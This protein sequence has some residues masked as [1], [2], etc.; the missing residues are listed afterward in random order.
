[1]KTADAAPWSLRWRLLAATFVATVAVAVL[2]GVWLSTL[3]RDE[4]A[5]Q[6][7]AALRTQ[8]DEVTARF[9]L[10]AAGVPA[11]DAAALSDPRWHQPQ[12]GLYWQ[13]DEIGAQGSS[14]GALRSRSLW[15]AQLDSPTDLLAGGQTH[16]HTLTGPDGA[17][18]LALERTV[19]LGAGDATR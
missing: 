1:M 19:Q 7:A 12:S 16:V 9:E 2:A 14:R 8:L 6:F 11:V 10:D 3:F 13:V 4:V 17:P 15:D 18:L 5:R